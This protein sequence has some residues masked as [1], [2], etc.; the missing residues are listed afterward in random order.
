MNTST[1]SGFS[2][3]ELLIM[4]AVVGIILSFG[5]P[6][7]QSSSSKG[8]IAAIADDL[9]SSFQLA[10]SEAVRVGSAVTI[11]GSLAPMSAAAAC[12]GAFEDGWIVFADADGD[13]VRDAGEDVIR[14]FP[15]ADGAVDVATNDGA[16]YFSFAATG[17]GRGNVADAGTALARAVICDERGNRRAEGDNSTARVVVAT[18]VGWST[19]LKAKSQVDTQISISKLACP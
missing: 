5:V 7:F 12:D 6:S 17:F 8:Q 4:L 3:Y 10:R 13:I 2:F 16:D 15:P 19:V 14:A 18:P 11:C 9:H 1:Q